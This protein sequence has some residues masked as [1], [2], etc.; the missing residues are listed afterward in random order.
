MGTTNKWDESTYQMYKIRTAQLYEKC[1]KTFVE[2]SARYSKESFSCRGRKYDPDGQIA[3]QIA[4]FGAATARLNELCTAMDSYWNEYNGML[5]SSQGTMDAVE[6]SGEVYGSFEGLVAGSAA[7]VSTAYAA[8]TAYQFHQ[9]GFDFNTDFNDVEAFMNSINYEFFEGVQGISEIGSWQSHLVDVLLNGYGNA[10]DYSSQLFEAALVGSLER[11]PGY[12]AMGEEGKPNWGYLG[13]QIGMPGLGKDIEKV[14]KWIASVEGAVDYDELTAKISEVFFAAGGDNYH[15]CE[16]IE[17]IGEHELLG[18][19]FGLLTKAG[20]SFGDAAKTLLDMYYHIIANHIQQVQYLDSIDEALAMGGYLGDLSNN[21]SLRG[22]LQEIRESFVN[23]ERY[24][25]DKAYDKVESVLNDALGGA[26]TEATDVIGQ[27]VIKQIC[28]DVP[29]LSGIASEISVTKYAD[30]VLD[31]ISLTF[32]IAGK[33]Q[34]A[35]VETIQGIQMYTEPLLKSFDR[36]MEM[37]DAG[38]ASVEDVQQAENL[39]QLI[40][41]SKTKEY[42]AMLTLQSQG[43]LAIELGQK[44]ALLERMESLEDF[45]TI[46]NSH[47]PSGKK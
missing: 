14:L 2:M 5:E 4:R 37:M 21:S 16:L 6:V 23:E 29:S 46:P 25:L 30:L 24:F 35:A 12:E 20:F 28:S 38:A 17:D 9:S 26:V 1:Q 33:D 22:R 47:L 13:E 40:R 7:A 36:Y 34:I 42:E 3:E 43:D 45:A 39:F 32:D 44:L 10:T 19:L 31:G 18:D 15:V 41:A 8:S 11:V 27:L